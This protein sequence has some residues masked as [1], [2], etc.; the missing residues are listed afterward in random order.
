MAWTDAENRR[1]QEIEKAI[2]EHGVALGNLASKRQLN[3]ML[4]LLTKENAELKAR[5]DALESQL[6]MLT[7]K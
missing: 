1:V 3:H 5:I 4:T 2:S 7:N 6:E